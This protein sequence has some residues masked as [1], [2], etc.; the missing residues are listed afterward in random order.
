LGSKYIQRTVNSNI[1]K[2]EKEFD[3]SIQNDGFQNSNTDAGNEDTVKLRIYWTKD[4]N[5]LAF[6]RL[7]RLQNQMDLLHANAAT[8]VSN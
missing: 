1:Q 4:P 5:Q 3:V 6:I 7:N 8:G 2:L